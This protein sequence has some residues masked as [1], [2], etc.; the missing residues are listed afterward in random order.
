MIDAVIE[1]DVQ[2]LSA[3]HRV[4]EGD[5]DKERGFADAMARNDQADVS[6]AQSATMN[7]I[8]YSV[9]DRQI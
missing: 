8:S 9:P 5:A 6:A 1:R 4:V 2:R 3:A 7:V